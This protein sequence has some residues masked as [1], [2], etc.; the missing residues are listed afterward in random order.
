[1]NHWISVI[2]FKTGVPGEANQIFVLDSS[3]LKHMNLPDEDMVMLSLES[4]CWKKIRLG[5][6]PTIKFM[7]EMSIQSL[8]D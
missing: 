5:M 6:K 3:N 8:F 4:R 7:V 2:I 1:V